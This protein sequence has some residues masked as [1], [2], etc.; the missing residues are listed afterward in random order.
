M[1]TTLDF[2]IIF[3]Q[4]YE[5][6]TKIVDK[7][8]LTVQNVVL[9]IANIMQFVEKVEGI[10]G[11]EKKAL[12]IDVLVKVIEESDLDEETEE[13]LSNFIEN[14][15]PEVIDVIIAASKHKFDLNTI[16]EHGSKIKKLLT[17]LNCR[18]CNCFERKY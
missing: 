7:N 6:A 3:D 9:L 13:N 15:L 17:Y 11:M 10:E 14:S 1:S 2:E 8:D 16:I 5:E 18:N 12:V 4:A